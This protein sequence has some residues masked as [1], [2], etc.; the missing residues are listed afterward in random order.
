MLLNTFST[1]IVLIILE[2]VSQ[3]YGFAIHVG[4]HF[5]KPHILRVLVM[6]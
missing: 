1:D 6:R 4:N 5:E 2:N 3:S